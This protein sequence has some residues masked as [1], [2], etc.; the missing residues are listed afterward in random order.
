M[1]K[2]FQL[3]AIHHPNI[4]ILCCIG[5]VFTS[6]VD[7]VASFLVIIAEIMYR[8]FFLLATC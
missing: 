5:S 3:D 4:S 2:R 6:F 1:I 7:Q 8:A